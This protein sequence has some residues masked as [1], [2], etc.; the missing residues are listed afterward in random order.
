MGNYAVVL[1]SN[2]INHTEALISFP[3]TTGTLIGTGDTETVTNGM[4]AGSIADSKLST[5]ST[6][7]KVALSA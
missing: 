7:G 5:I 1:G 2:K 3:T 4:L 6:A